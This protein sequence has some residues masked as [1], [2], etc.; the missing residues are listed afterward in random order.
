MSDHHQLS[1]LLLHQLGDGVGALAQG[2]WPLGGR[3]NLLRH[4]LLGAGTQAVPLGDQRLRLVLLKNL[5]QRRGCGRRA[6]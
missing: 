2:E 6:Q 5:E 1:L 4:L 3:V